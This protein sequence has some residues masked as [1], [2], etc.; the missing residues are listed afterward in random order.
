MNGFGNLQSP[1]FSRGVNEPFISPTVPQCQMRNG[2]ILPQKI[3]IRTRTFKFPLIS[4]ILGLL[5]PKGQFVLL[6]LE[7]LNDTIIEFT[8]DE[9][10]FFTSGFNDIG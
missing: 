3:P 1:I 9:S 10:A 4:A 8:L 6:P 2:I 5:I 7:A